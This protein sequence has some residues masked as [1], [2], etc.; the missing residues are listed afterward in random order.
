MSA[1]L[2]G[3]LGYETIELYEQMPSRKYE[4]LKVPDGFFIRPTVMVIFDGIK[5]GVDFYFVHSYH[6]IC[7]KNEQVFGLTEYGK[8]FAS[9]VA[10]DNII[11][12][13]FHPEK[14]QSNGMKLI[15]NFCN[16]KGFC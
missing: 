15:E 2:I 4:E 7:E 16:W 9:I 10:Q 11:G 8:N 3:Y 14:S 6:F 13:Q 12:L 5:N 1:G